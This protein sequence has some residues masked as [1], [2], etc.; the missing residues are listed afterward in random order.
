MCAG[1]STDYWTIFLSSVIRV[2]GKY[3]LQTAPIFVPNS[4]TTGLRVKTLFEAKGTDIFIQ[5]GDLAVRLDHDV[6]RA[7]IAVHQS[8]SM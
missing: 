7:D 3:C 2:P 5:Y 6:L 4:L 1:R 8:R